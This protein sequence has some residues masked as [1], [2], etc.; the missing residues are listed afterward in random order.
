MIEQL[1]VTL[2]PAVPVVQSLPASIVV[3]AVMLLATKAEGPSVAA[4][5]S[6]LS[7][8]VGQV[9]FDEASGAK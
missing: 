3:G 1:A 6:V 8:S 4:T 9:L 5:V 7:G 2:H